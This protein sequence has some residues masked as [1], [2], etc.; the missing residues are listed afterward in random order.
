VLA[1]DIVER[2][3]AEIFERSALPRAAVVD[4]AEEI[5]RLLDH[6]DHQ[7]RGGGIALRSAQRGAEF[8][9]RQV[10]GEQHIAFDGA[11]VRRPVGDDLRRVAGEEIAVALQLRWPDDFVDIAFHHL[12]AHHGAARLKLL[13]RH[14][15][16]RQHVTVGAVFLGD[17]P[18]KLVDRGERHRSADQVAVERGE[19][20]A[21]IDGRADDAHV[22]NDELDVFGT[23]RGDG[24]GK[25]NRRAARLRARRRRRRELLALAPGGRH[26]N[27]RGGGA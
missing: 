26:G 14:D 18:G 16:A 21:G 27:L 25:G 24:A 5:D 17:A 23:G 11:D 13:R 6:L 10:A 3:V 12:D 19:L 22:A 2:H 8:Q 9:A 4:A 1:E 15:G 7:G 20:V